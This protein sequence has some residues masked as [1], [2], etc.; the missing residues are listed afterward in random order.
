MKGRRKQTNKK[1]NKWKEERKKNLKTCKFWWKAKWNL[2]QLLVF[3]FWLLSGSVSGFLSAPGLTLEKNAP[4][5]C[6]PALSG[7]VGLPSS[8]R[9]DKEEGIEPCFPFLALLQ[10]RGLSLDYGNHRCPV[11]SPH[12]QNAVRPA[13][14]TVGSCAELAPIVRHTLLCFPQ[15]VRCTEWEQ[16]AP[17]DPPF[18]LP[19]QL[20]FCRPCPVHLNSSFEKCLFEWYCCSKALPSFPHTLTLWQVQSLS[21]SWPVVVHL[22]SQLQVPQGYPQSLA[23][24][25]PATATPARVHCQMCVSLCAVFPPGNFIHSSLS[26]CCP[27][28]AC[29]GRVGSC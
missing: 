2:S 20:S 17:H 7:F 28:F 5:C 4:C 8:C 11:S 25:Q 9:D 18:F 6:K 12:P 14:S 29:P 26:W 24:C 19:R 10:V 21:Q 22:F 27:Q 3:A 1:L 15:F 16:I 13:L 23:L